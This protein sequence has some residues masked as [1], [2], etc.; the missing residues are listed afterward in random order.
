MEFVINYLHHHR[1]MTQLRS[2]K[3][4]YCTSVIAINHYDFDDAGRIMIVGRP[5][6]L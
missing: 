6:S 5:F 4:M 1:F 3:L 2:E